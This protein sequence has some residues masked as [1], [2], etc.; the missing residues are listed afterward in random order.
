MNLRIHAVEPASLANGPGLRAVVWFQGCTLGCPGCFNPATHNASAGGD[1]DT[2]VLAATFLG[3]SEIAGIN[4]SGGEPFQQPEALLDLLTRL[5]GSPL[6]IV[7]FSG[8]TLAEIQ[9]MPLGPRIL[10]RLDVLIAGRY[11]HAQHLGVGL[12]GSANQRIH[13]LSKR[14]AP[15][16]FTRLP[17]GEAIIHRDGSITLSGIHPPSTA[18][19]GLRGA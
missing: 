5:E 17:A 15:S 13:L 10:S 8:Y 11:L 18:S 7:C 4:L 1:V 6:S 19:H 12:L 2:G 14:Y 9:T 3:I 16:D